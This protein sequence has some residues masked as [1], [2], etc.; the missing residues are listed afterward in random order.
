[1][2]RESPSKYGGI[3]AV[4]VLGVGG[5]LVGKT[6]IGIE[7]LALGLFAL[8]IALSRTLGRKL[9]WV[10]IAAIIVGGILFYSAAS[11]EITGTANHH[12]FAHKHDPGEAVTRSASPVKFRQATN[13]LW[14]LGVFCILVSGVCFTFYRALDDCE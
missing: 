14:G 9:L 1:M 3:A 13:L 4:F 12:N 5:L 10:A 8:T 6:W 7:A 11:N 2:I